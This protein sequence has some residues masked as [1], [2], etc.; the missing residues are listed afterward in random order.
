MLLWGFAVR[1]LSTVL[2]IQ[3]SDEV[4]QYVGGGG[5]HISTLWSPEVSSI[6]SKVFVST[7]NGRHDC[8]EPESRN[9]LH[10]LSVQNVSGPAWG[11]REH[12]EVQE[13]LGTAWGDIESGGKFNS[14]TQISPYPLVSLPE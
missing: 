7:Q 14:T 11:D 2:L 10:R 13:V 5:M 8:L 1:I 6:K 12:G 3:F 9:P 4:L